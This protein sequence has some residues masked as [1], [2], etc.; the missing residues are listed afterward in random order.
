MKCFVKII[1][2]EKNEYYTFVWEFKINAWR[3]QLLDSTKAAEQTYAVV[4]SK[5]DNR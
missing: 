3:I 1:S 2:R 4:A 5:E